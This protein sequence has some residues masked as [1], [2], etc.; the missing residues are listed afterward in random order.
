MIDLIYQR[1]EKEFGEVKTPLNY[2]EPYQLAIAVI[3]S[4]QCT[5]ERVNQVTPKLFS[6]YNSAKKLALAP[7]SEIEEIIFSTGFYK[8]KAK[9]IKKFCEIFVSKFNCILPKNIE[10]LT[11]MPGV[12]RK[13]ANVILQEIYGIIEGIVV[14]THVIRISQ[15]LNLTKNTNAITIEK[16]LIKVIPQK[17]WLKWSLY[18]IFLGRKYCIARKPKCNICILSDICPK[19]FVKI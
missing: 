17:Y 11:Q 12:G 9:N 6:K 16:D 14:D 19:K 10:E 15:I 13:T 8:N 2:K 7:I 18:M 4:A 1:L 5:D 3:L